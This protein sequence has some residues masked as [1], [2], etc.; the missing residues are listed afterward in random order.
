MRLSYVGGGPSLNFGNLGFLV[1]IWGILCSSD[2][3]V[4]NKGAGN[5]CGMGDECHSWFLIVF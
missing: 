3:H 4:W 2:G 5:P 1:L